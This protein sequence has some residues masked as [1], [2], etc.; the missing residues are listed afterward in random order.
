MG[1]VVAKAPSSRATPKLSREPQAWWLVG[2]LAL[3]VVGLVAIPISVWHQPSYDALYS[4]F[5]SNLISVDPRGGGSSAGFIQTS[6]GS[7]ELTAVPSS[8]PTVNLLSSQMDFRMA[9]D[10][11]VNDN[12]VGTSPLQIS[13]WNPR[14]D[15]RYLLDFGPAPLN[16]IRSEVRVNNV[17]SEM[18][19]LG[20]Y[21]SGLAYHLELWLDRRGS[22]LRVLL[23]SSEKGNPGSKAVLLVG[24]PSEAGYRELMSDY[25]P[26][27]SG[28]D[29]RFGGTVKLVSGANSYKLI[30]DW[31][32]KRKQHLASSNDWQPTSSLNGWTPK[33]FM[34][35][36]PKGAAYARMVLGAGD[37]RTTLLLSRLFLAQ[38]IPPNRNLL[39][40]G[41]FTDGLKAWSVAGA[42]GPGQPMQIVDPAQGPMFSD[43][44]ASKA[45]GLFVDLPVAVTARSASPTGAGGIASAT[46]Q[47]LHV[48]LPTQNW[49]AM[50]VNDPHAIQ[51]II[52]LALLCLLALLVAIITWAFSKS[53]QVYALW[54]RAWLPNGPGASPLIIR[55]GPLIL[56][57]IAAVGYLT[58]NVASFQLG[59]HSFD[60]MGEKT[61]SYVGAQYSTSDI[62]FLSGISSPAKVWAGVPYAGEIFPYGPVMAYIFTGIGWLYRILFAGPGNLRLDSFQLEFLI[63]TANVLFGLADA[64]LIYAILRQ[65]GVRTKLC[66]AAGALFLFNPATWFVMSVWGETQTISLSFILLS[67]WFGL[68]ANATPAW[69]ALGAA[70][71]TRPQMLVPA[72]LL[73]IY[74]LRSFPFRRNIQAISWSVI[75]MFLVLSPLLLNT[76]PSLPV[77]YITQSIHIQN[78]TAP[79]AAKYI[80]VSYDGYNI[81]PLVTNL[82]SGQIGKAR[83]YF[84]AS[85]SL[86]AGL[87]YTAV[88]NALTLAMIATLGLGLMFRRRL[89]ARAGVLLPFLAAATLGFVVLRTGASP[90]HFILALG[91]VVLTIG[92]FRTRFAYLMVVAVISVTTFV[93]LFGSLGVALLIAPDFGPAL[94]PRTNAI[95]K[96]FMTWYQSDVFITLATVANALALV[97]LVVLAF[98]P[99]K[100]VN[101]TLQLKPPVGAPHDPLVTVAHLA[102]DA[103]G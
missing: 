54:R 82:V 68:R 53:G 45:P 34:A 1:V 87:S 103:R 76:S 63:K 61:F 13:V 49:L 43:I 64:L 9:F 57:V 62:Y 24:G 89:S 39:A 97:V 96:M 5:D 3:L 72:L 48:G 102:G 95:T 44:T 99:F 35:P 23:T 30:V 46:L 27:V 29:Y 91:L 7:V 37:G 12:P 26:V 77:D 88:S 16:E 42:S 41:D 38:A 18:R 98:R 67:L 86:I 70:S 52:G 81:W 101:S 79:G 71:L 2:V 11:R 33:E 66:L 22:Q 78:S 40:N 17:P 75:A 100:S 60:M 90:H 10:L 92:S 36:A 19:T 58:I 59:S 94:D 50:R 55:K 32:D 93:S 4:G 74:F 80:Y 28:R 8:Q 6:P 31:Y 73:A 25:I 51:L 85:Q 83:I 56:A 14:E 47:N 65:L 84:P 20:V 21:A 15:T 69:L